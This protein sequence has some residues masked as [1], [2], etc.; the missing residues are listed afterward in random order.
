MRNPYFLICDG[1]TFDLSTC[2]E[3]V[4]ELAPNLRERTVMDG[5]WTVD[6]GARARLNQ[7]AENCARENKES[8]VHEQNFVSEVE[9]AERD[10]VLDPLPSLSPAADA[11]AL[12]QPC[13]PAATAPPALG[14]G[15]QVVAPAPVDPNTDAAKTQRGQGSP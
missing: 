9:A 15:T 8:S 7:F 6:W 11:G 4:G 3:L 2:K 1:R 5:D 12:T 10:G 14:P 13:S